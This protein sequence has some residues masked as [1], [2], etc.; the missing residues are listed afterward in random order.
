LLPL[1]TLTSTVSGDH[2]RQD[3]KRTSGLSR[4][5]DALA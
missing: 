4:K 1:K 2:V 5:L 3:A